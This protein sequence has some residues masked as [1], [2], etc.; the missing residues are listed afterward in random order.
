MADVR[1][2]EHI[3][4]L[5]TGYSLP[6]IHTALIDGSSQRST[7]HQRVR[8]VHSPSSTTGRPAGSSGIASAPNIQYLI[9]R[10]DLF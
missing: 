4:M 7:Y 8:D 6:L 9:Y 1:A 3:V 10:I 2:H 5:P